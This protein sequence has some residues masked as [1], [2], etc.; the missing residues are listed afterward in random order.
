LGRTAGKVFMEPQRKE[1]K[2][3]GHEG[4]YARFKGFHRLLLIW[5]KRFILPGSESALGW[6]H[7]L[8]RDL[9]E[10]KGKPGKVHLLVWAK[11]H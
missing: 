7:L 8:S 2:H 1:L 9:T 6:E 5:H 10:P 3:D 4:A 11:R